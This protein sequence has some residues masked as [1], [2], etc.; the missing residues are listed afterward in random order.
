MENT[1]K[2]ITLIL[3]YIPWKHINDWLSIIMYDFIYSDV[4]LIDC[5]T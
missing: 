5:A 2:E 3:F 1:S 4:M